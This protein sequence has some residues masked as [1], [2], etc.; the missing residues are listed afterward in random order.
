MLL[1]IIDKTTNGNDDELINIVFEHDL[2]DEQFYI[3]RYDSPFSRN[4]RENINWYYNE[5]LCDRDDK[6]DDRG[7][8]EKLIKFGQYLG[9]QLLGEDHQ[10][11][12][13]M[14]LIEEQGYHNLQVQIES[15]RVEFFDE[16]WEAMVFPE[17]KY[18]LAA[19]VKSFV[20]KFSSLENRAEHVEVCYGLKTAPVSAESI[21]SLVQTGS[22]SCSGPDRSDD[23]P[24]CILHAVF[25]P[26]SRSLPRDPSNAFNTGVE[27]LATEG[28][29]HYEIYPVSCWSELQKRL[30]DSSRPV[31]IL[32]IDSTVLVDNESVSF[33]S[34]ESQ[35]KHQRIDVSDLVK[36]LVGNKVAVL[37]VDARNYINQGK[38]VSNNT[39]LSRIAQIAEAAGL[40]NVIGL[41]HS[42]DPWTSS[43]CFRRFYYF[44]VKGLTPSQAVVEA[45]KALQVI[46]E[47]SRFTSYAMPFNMWSLLV[48]YGGQ[49]LTFFETP[50]EVSNA[51]ESHTLARIQK[52][53]FGFKSQLLSPPLSNTGDG[54]FL[55]SFEK[56]LTTQK[57]PALIGDEGMGKTHLTHQLC[58]YFL[59]SNQCDYG[60]YFD[61]ETDF[62][63]PDIILE[64]I[65]SVL[66]VISKTRT[67]IEKKLRE[68][69][70]CFV[71]DNILNVPSKSQL[72]CKEVEEFL[73]ELAA[74]GHKVIVTGTAV[75]PSTLYIEI[76]I[77]PLLL[78]EQ[79]IL[80]AESLRYN[81]LHGKDRD[82]EWEKLLFN[83]RGNPFLIKKVIPY[84]NSCDISELIEKI[85][86]EIPENLEKSVVAAFYQ[87][88]WE[89]LPQ[90]W[91][92]LLLLSATV[93]GLILEILMIACDQ[94]NPFTPAKTL[95]RELGE[96][97]GILVEGLDLWE[98][99]GFVNRLPQ[100]RVIDSRCEKYLSTKSELGR[101]GKLKSKEIKLLLSQVICEGIRR[102]SLHL[103]TESNPV[104]CHKLLMNRREWVQHFE[105]L[106]FAAD[107][108]GFIGV[109]NAFDQLLK[110]AELTEESSAWSLDLLIRSE[111]ISVSEDTN[112]EARLSWLTVAIAALDTTGAEK[113]EVIMAGVS[114][115]RDW[116][117]TAVDALKS[118]QLQLF[119]HAKIFLELFYRKNENWEECIHISQKSCDAYIGYEA[120]HQVIQCYRSLTMYHVAIGKSVEASVFEDQ[121]LHKIDYG[122]LPSDFEIRQIME[123]ALAR[124]GRKDFEKAQ[125]LVDQ[126]KGRKDANQLYEIIDELQA[127]ILFQKHNYRESMCHYCRMWKRAVNSKQ[128]ARMQKLSQR[129]AEIEEQ[130]G[131]EAFD[132]L[133]T[134]GTGDDS[135]TPRNQVEFHYS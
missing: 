28:A 56:M 122:G 90:I 21:V 127:E 92:S 12:K 40:G 113:E 129:F 96:E 31:H 112:L 77:T 37:C 120:W 46:T 88:Q 117:D 13:Y 67:D 4:F 79:K 2:E 19:V 86:R 87:W 128:K 42:V 36:S 64:M 48:H 106:W 60:F 15:E 14:R 27:L 17:S 57:I 95:L 85:D 20:R 54:Q 124:I 41:S 130:L 99:S 26:G 33:G 80:A 68:L 126:I 62:Y 119:Q 7:V 134:Q 125:V 71:L 116:F 22:E 121:I 53:L 23:K 115:W 109:K 94:K 24:L 50:Q 133:F 108:R 70:C 123:T 9:D 104:L 16:L 89:E 72:A 135:I 25:R 131:T 32:H 93:N 47:A 65:G 81:N 97:D 101:F 29:I 74:V 105:Q 59:Q 10:L 132:K 78:E 51:E 84:L 35:G 69:C 52:N 5:Y 1:R 110:A 44:L 38:V 45:R 18:I 76:P 8:V 34:Y 82:K 3:Y 30:D 107:Y 98:K 83:L 11:T 6:P 61:F 114:I 66:G 73:Q 91:Q 111:K 58:F 100:G 43:E 102:L 63:S 75:S 103:S 39:G 118:E 49:Q 55:L